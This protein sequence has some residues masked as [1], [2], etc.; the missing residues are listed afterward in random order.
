MAMRLRLVP[1][2]LGGLCWSLPRRLAP[3]LPLLPAAARASP[4]SSEDVQRMQSALSAVRRIGDFPSKASLAAAEAQLDELLSRWRSLE[5]QPNEL[6]ALL[7]RRA[8]AAW[9]SLVR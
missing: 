1:L 4:P 6:P 8:Y 3:L 9:T 7:R 5:V 2:L